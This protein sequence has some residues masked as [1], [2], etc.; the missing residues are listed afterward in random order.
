MWTGDWSS[1]V[2]SSDLAG[3]TGP[4]RP[5]LAA[6]PQS[7]VR[8]LGDGSRR[9]AIRPADEIGRASCRERVEMAAVAGSNELSAR[10]ARLHSDI[11]S[12]VAARGEQMRALM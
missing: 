12:A 5:L 6:R 10:D 7:A 4:Q 11:T 9:R 2:C 8:R 3:R 1:D